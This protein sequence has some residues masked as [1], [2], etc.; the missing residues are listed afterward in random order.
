MAGQTDTGPAD[1]KKS[2]AMLSTVVKENSTLITGVAAFAALTAFFSTQLKD[3]DLQVALPAMTLLGAF[4]LLFELI[5]CTPAPPHHW[6]L[7]VFQMVLAMLVLYVGWYWLKAFPVVWVPLVGA[8]LNAVLVLTFPIILTHLSGKLVRLVAKRVH[9][10][11][12]NA[13]LI[14][15]QQVLFVFLLL[16]NV[17]G[18][19][20]VAHKLI[21]HEIKVKVPF[22]SG[23]VMANGDESG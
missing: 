21:P 18:Y 6:R 15:I 11:I 9:K 3:A 1:A 12:A 7:S 13:T 4:L 22:V 10:E 2:K 20:W 16:A 23:H 19:F 17:V 5:A 14:K 8:I